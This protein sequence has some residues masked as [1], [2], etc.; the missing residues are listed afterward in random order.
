MIHVYPTN[1]SD[2][3]DIV[4]NTCKCD[5]TLIADPDCEMILVHNSFDGKEKDEVTVSRTK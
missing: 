3:H 4:T 5:P 2:E 1:D